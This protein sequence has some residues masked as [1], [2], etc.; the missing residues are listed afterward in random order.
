MARGSKAKK[1][2]GLGRGGVSSRA[3]SVARGSEN[4]REFG[5]GP[6]FRGPSL[7]G[8]LCSVKKSDEIQG[9]VGA[10]DAVV[11]IGLASEA[12]PDIS[13]RQPGCL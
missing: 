6:H 12:A 2:C 1:T 7:P 11:Q 8:S 10:I 9:P 3:T 13:R 4:L 5:D